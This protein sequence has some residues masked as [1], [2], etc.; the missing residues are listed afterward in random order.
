[1]K[2]YNTIS[3]NVEQF[4]PI[5]KG[6]VGMYTCGPT[7]YDS[8][9]IGNLRTYTLSDLLRK[10]F[11]AAGFEVKQVMN[12]TD[13]EDKI[14]RKSEGKREKF[15]EVVEGYEKKFWN[16]LLELNISKPDIITHVTTYIEKI[17]DFI[18]DL[19]QKGY[20]YKTVDGSVYYSIGKFKDYGK[21]ARLDKENLKIGARV[22][23]DEYDKE[24]PSD[25]VLWKAWG[26]KDG[27]VFWNT[28]LG[29]GRPGWHIE[30]SAMAIDTLGETIDVHTGAVD[31]IFPHHENEIAQS[32]ARTGKKFVNFWVH[33]EHLLVDNKKMSKS[34]QNF[35]TL[36][37]IKAK[38]FAPLD[39][40]YLVLQSHY[41]SKMNFTWEG[42][43]SAKNSRERLN[44]IIAEL[45]DDAGKADGSYEKKFSDAIFNDLNVPQALAVVWELL[46]DEKVNDSVKWAT[47]LEF[48]DVLGLKLD[49]I[50]KTKIDIPAEVIKIADERKISR[51]NKDFKASDELRT[52]LN[53]LGWQ[54]ED[55]ADNE[56]RVE[57]ING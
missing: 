7:V 43:E 40:R 51:Q 10:S 30:C 56:Y 22:M 34:L 12:I 55:L 9:H 14:I 26:E 3:R 52:K 45:P 27:E 16:D 32:E 54:I 24:N 19:V 31:L 44:R 4:E 23:Q 5:E 50:K 21:L 42:L 15:K 25:F 11:I 36:D 38:G 41:R 48:D 1:M 47:V 33:G 17:V 2:I 49:K 29:K 39:F 13:I 53:S 8:A 6:K 57:K 18:E 28:S 37:D 35:Y 46:R 20:A